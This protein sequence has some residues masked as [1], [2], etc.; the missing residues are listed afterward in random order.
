MKGKLIAV[1]GLDGC[2]KTA[3]VIKIGQYLASRRVR[4]IHS[5]AISGWSTTLG[6]QIGDILRD[7]QTE[8]PIPND[9][10]HALMIAARVMAEK[11]VIEPAINRGWWVVSDRYGLCGLVY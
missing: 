11:N 1:S 7:P 9:A 8:C 5:S 3:L 10:E 2:G 4:V 6:R